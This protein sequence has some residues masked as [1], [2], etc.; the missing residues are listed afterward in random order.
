[1]NVSLFLFS[2]T[3]G[4]ERVAAIL[5]SELGDQVRIHDLTDRS[6]N[7]ENAETDPG[8]IAVIAVPVFGGR[9]PA[10]AA[11]RIRTVNGS[12]ASCVAVCVYGNRAYDDALLELADLAETQGFR[13]TAAVAAV[14]EHSIIRSF[15]A[16]RPDAADD[17]QLRK[18]GKRIVGKLALIR[19]GGGF[20]VPGR[21]PYRRPAGTGLRPKADSSCVGC[22]LCASVCPAGAIDRRDPRKADPRKCM[23]CMRCVSECPRHARAISGLMTCLAS[24]AL[25]KACSSRKECEVYM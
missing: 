9:V 11:E 8:G 14:A 7:G 16:G 24:L 20:A 15:A 25:R 2:P 5:C 4:T 22:G 1:M 12:G 6:F 3:G 17:R 18:I 19:S 13:L 10:A 23:S 21:R